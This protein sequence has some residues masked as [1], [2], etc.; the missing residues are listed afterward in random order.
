MALREGS[1]D[2]VEVCF[3]PVAERVWRAKGSGTSSA[4]ARQGKTVRQRAK[5]QEGLVMEVTEWEVQ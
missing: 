1:Q 5:K 2:S 4:P 3:V